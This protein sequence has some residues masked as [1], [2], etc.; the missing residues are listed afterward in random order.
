MSPQPYPTTVFVLGTERNIGK[1]VTC[2]GII[3]K[4]LS[5][6]H[7]YAIGDIGYLK[8]VG[9]Q[10]VKV[11]N[12][13]GVTLDVD[14][15]AVLLTTLL[16]V[17][18]TDYADL[19][20]VVWRGG[21]TAA[22][23]DEAAAGDPGQCREALLAKIREAYDHV[24]TG[25]R[26]VI[27][28]GTG[29][30]GVGSVAGI[31]NADVINTLRAMGV[32]LSVILIAPGGIG[33]T[34]DEIF[35]YLMT[36]DHVGCKLDG[37]IINGVIP[38]KMDKVRSY[39]ETY[40]TRVFPHLYGQQ[41]TSQKAPP[42]LGFVPIIDELRLPS[43][44]LAADTL[45]EEPDNETK[46]IAPTD[47]SQA[48][49]LIRSLKVISLDFGYESFIKPGDAVVVG[50]NANDAILSMLLLHERLSR[51]HGMG[52]SGLILSCCSM[53]G[54]SQQI[55]DLIGSGDLP[56]ITLNRDSAEIV[57]RIENMTVKIQPYDAAKKELI[58]QAYREYLT[59]WPQLQDTH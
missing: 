38:S 40:Y 15:D 18:R 6:E 39:L 1:T 35:P 43:M 59:L 34:I 29:Q 57:Q 22:F 9:Q 5:P 30:P 23:I 8:P 54:L 27:V 13:K 33:N 3:S 28:E 26:I 4:L 21:S 58:A 47:F 46:I 19:S 44:R 24:A 37:L 32:P 14:K 36:L 10:T 53:G 51:H 52:L 31:S 16:N 55:R 49:Q 56:T 12:M 48:C 20:P 45:A 17:E 11:V 2:M 7:G 42:I 25:R 41:L 50:V